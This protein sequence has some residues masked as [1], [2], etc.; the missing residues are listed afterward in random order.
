VNFAL[1]LF[2]ATAITGAIWLIDHLTL[3]RRRPAEAKLPLVVEYARSFFPV[4]LAVFLLRSFLVEP[5]KIPSGSMLP[6]LQIGDFI[7]VNKYQY[8]VRLP[9]INKKIVELGTP[10]RGDV[11]VF[12][13]PQDQR[14][15]YIKRV[16]GVPGDVIEYREGKRLSINGQPVARQAVGEYAYESGGLNWVRGQQYRETL[17]AGVHTALVQPDMPPVIEH[18]VLGDFAFRENCRYEDAGFRCTV[19]AGH[20]FMMGD[21]RDASNDS[22]YWG[23]VPDQNIVGR[24]FFIWFNFDDFVASLK[25]LAA[26]KR[27]GKLI[28]DV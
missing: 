19:P 17:T 4:I 9:V 16:I 27:I 22:R 24:A 21:N 18:Q 13:F 3:A 8:G 6:T 5:F 15:D 25:G 28:A 26:P 10:Q 7:L 14:L 12:R 20:Y 2:S 1:I 23:F 11:M